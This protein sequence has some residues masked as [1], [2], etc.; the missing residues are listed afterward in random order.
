MR[1]QQHREHEQSGRGI[2]DG[3]RDQCDDDELDDRRD[4]DDRTAG[5]PQP[6]PEGIPLEQGPDL[7]PAGTTSQGA[8]VDG[9]QCAPIEQLAYHIH[10]HLQVYVSGQPRALPA[11]IGMVGPVAEQTPYGPFYGAQQCYYWLHTHASDGIIHIESPTARVYTLGN[12]FDE[13][14]QPLSGTQVA[15]D[16]GKVTAFVN[17]KPWTKSPRDIPL[18]PHESI[19]LDVGTAD[20]GAAR[21]L[22]RRHEPVARFTEPG[23]AGDGAGPRSRPRRARARPARSPVTQPT[24]EMMSSTAVR[25]SRTP[26]RSRPPTPPRSRRSSRCT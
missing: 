22:L 16:K 3:V 18:V 10:A 26:G 19:Q 4:L 1:R 2:L 12:F 13:W 9:V 17:D 5:K 23:G 11:A 8:T 15:G 21:D 24:S 7:A 6:G 25:R 20:R 14:N